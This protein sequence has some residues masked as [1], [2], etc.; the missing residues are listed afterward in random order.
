M[1][2]T[3]TTADSALKELYLPKL[4]LQLNDELSPTLTQLERSSEN[5]EGRRVVLSV[6]YGRNVGVGSKAEGAALPVAGNQLY[7]EERVGLKYHYGRIQLNGPVIRAMKSDKGSFVR[8]IEGEVSRIVVDLKQVIGRQV[9]NTA[10]QELARCGTT[11]AATEIILHSSTTAT[12]MRSFQVGMLIDCGTSASPTADLSAVAITAIN[13]TAG[14][15][16]VTTATA[17]TTDASDYITMA[18]ASGNE[19]TGLQQ[20]VA[21]S[22]TLHNI[23][24]ATY[25]GW[26]SYVDTNS[27]TNRTLTDNILMK[28]LDNVFIDSGE[29]VDLAVTSYGVCRAYSAQL[30][31]QKRF[32]NSQ[33]LKGGHQGIS[34]SSGSQTIGLMADRFAPENN[35]FLLN[36]K[37]IKFHQAADWEFMQEDGAVLDRVTGYDAYEAVLFTYRELMTDRRNA[38]GLIQD[39]T[40][41]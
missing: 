29:A 6:H 31:S 27:G 19:L 21:A 13:T 17:I 40:E 35:I 28:A 18:G 14:S 1:S 12:Q 11:S 15:Y 16:S 30:T 4:R 38:H 24:L 26:K 33:E 34:V 3:L 32:V 23:A 39:I 22:G 10:I 8:A 41:A 36:T 25:A 5:V 9:F 20:I 2:L 37:H 7:T